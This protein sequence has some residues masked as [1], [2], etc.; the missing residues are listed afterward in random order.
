[1]QWLGSWPSGRRFAGVGPEV[2]CAQER[3]NGTEA[4]RAED[5]AKNLPARR[6]DDHGCPPSARR[7]RSLLPR[8]RGS[9]GKVRI[10]A[11][12]LRLIRGRG[13]RDDY[14]PTRAPTGRRKSCLI[15]AAFQG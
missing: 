6:P 10:F 7:E 2:T 1:M 15:V 12:M 9:P 13:H 3:R 14:R 5:G 11:S 4:K 8:T